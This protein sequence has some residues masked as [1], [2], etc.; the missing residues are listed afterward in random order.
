MVWGS[1]HLGEL[2]EEASSSCS[3]RGAVPLGEPQVDIVQLHMLEN[4]AEH[5]IYLS[6]IWV[7]L[8]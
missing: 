4:S 8:W 7:S 6:H 5:S 1:V 2:V 3:F